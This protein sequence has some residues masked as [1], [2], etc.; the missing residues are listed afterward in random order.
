MDTSSV[1][2]EILQLVTFKLGSEE[3]AVDIL[4]VQEINRMVEFTQVPNSPNYLEGI[5]NLRGKVIPVVNLRKKLELA[6]K[7]NDE[8]SRIIILDIEWITMGIVVDSVSE[9]LRVPIQKVEP[10]PQLSPNINIEYIKGITQ[11]E[12]RIII[13][14]NMDKLLSSSEEETLIEATTPC[15]N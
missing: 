14:L 6:D 1:A 10:T 5:I 3:Y 9:V 8:N 4:N 7:D 13:L 2:D 12:N 11:L 15:D